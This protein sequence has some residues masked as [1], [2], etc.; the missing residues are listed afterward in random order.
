M[1][2][3]LH[4]DIDFNWT[5]TWVQTHGRSQPETWGGV[6]LRIFDFTSLK[7][8]HSYKNHRMSVVSG[9]GFGRPLKVLG[10]TLG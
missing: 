9:F 8:A 3:K 10:R 4:G 1:I 2:T 5:T 7:L 6:E